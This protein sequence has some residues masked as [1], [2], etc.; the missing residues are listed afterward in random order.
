MD[1]CFWNVEAR[2]H[3]SLDLLSKLSVGPEYSI[4]WRL[5]DC[6]H[7]L[8]KDCEVMIKLIVHASLLKDDN[9]RL[10]GSPIS[11]RFCDLC[12]H[13]AMDHARHLI[14]QCPEL[15]DHRTTTFREL[16]ESNGGL[17]DEILQAAPDT[18]LLLLGRETVKELL[19]VQMVEFW[20]IAARHIARMY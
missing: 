4:W 9:V 2:C 1:V 18:L 15:Q 17:G 10:K 14:M 11:N 16:A 5:S 8:M 6:N 13:A 19:S 3:R 7:M 20:S 12:D